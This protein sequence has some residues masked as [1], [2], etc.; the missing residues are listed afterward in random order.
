MND[1]S[2]DES[3]LFQLRLQAL[4]EWWTQVETGGDCGMTSW[5]VLVPFKDRVTACLGHSPPNLDEAESQTAKALM[6]IAGQ[7]TI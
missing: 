5:E 3:S 6:L 1:D 2:F 4:I 7:R